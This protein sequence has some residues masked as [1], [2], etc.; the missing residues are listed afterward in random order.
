M[1]KTPESD[2]AERMAFSSE[3]MVPTEVSRKLERERDEARKGQ[4]EALCDCQRLAR[5]ID[6]IRD[7]FDHQD[8]DWTGSTTLVKAVSKVIRERDEVRDEL[9]HLRACVFDVMSALDAGAFTELRKAW[10]EGAK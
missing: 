4:M 1:S 6:D 3:Y 7:V 5:Q 10:E 8:E 9:C 2:A